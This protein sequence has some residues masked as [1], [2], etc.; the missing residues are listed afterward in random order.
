MKN[1]VLHVPIR[2]TYYFHEQSGTSSWTLPKGVNEDVQSKQP[3]PVASSVSAAKAT[4]S[5]EPPLQKEKSSGSRSP[6]RLQ[7]DTRA[8]GDTATKAVVIDERPVQKEK[9]SGSH[10]PE[11]LQKDARTAVVTAATTA[12]S[13][14]RPVK[15]EKSSGSPTP[16]GTGKEINASKVSEPQKREGQPKDKAA[17]M[18]TVSSPKEER[19]LISSEPRLA[20]FERPT[21][22]KRHKKG[23]L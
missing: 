2:Q 15:K 5:D 11:R 7:E 19:K 23:G 20:N 3:D 14:K 9:S 8:V 22:P 17:T 13:D 12:E 4:V 10:A 18:V 1:E 6:E 16:T 21:S